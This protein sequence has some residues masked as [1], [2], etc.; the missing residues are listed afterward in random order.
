[1]RIFRICCKLES[2]PGVVGEQV[3][4]FRIFWMIIL[5]SPKTCVWVENFQFFVDFQGFRVLMQT[6]DSPR[7]GGGAGEDFQDDYPVQP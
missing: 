2:H 6:K 3:S 5:F 1:M 4:I 7:G